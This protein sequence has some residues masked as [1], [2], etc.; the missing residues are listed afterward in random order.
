MNTTSAMTG[1]RREAEQHYALGRAH[2]ARDDL[3]AAEQAYRQALALEPEY[4]DAWVSLGI[5]L[6]AAGQLAEAEKCQREALQLDSRS[7]LAL[8]NL[9][10]VLSSQSRFSE[11]AG[12]FRQALA[13][14][15]RSSKA[16]CNLGIALAQLNDPE[17]GGHFREALRLDPENFEAARHIGKLSLDSGKFEQAIDTLAHACKLQPDS[18]ETRF[19]LATAHFRFGALETARVQFEQLMSD[20]PAWAE[21]PAGLACVLSE[22]GQ[23]S[24]PRA[25]FE[26]ALELDPDD[27]LVRVYYSLLLLRQGEFARGWDFYESRSAA[28]PR[29]RGIERGFAAPR[30]QGEPLAGKTLLVT[31]EQGFGDELLFAS[32]LPEIA[33]DAAHAIVECNERLEKLFRRSFPNATVFGADGKEVGDDRL[34]ERSVDRLP[35]F[36][37]W[38][39]VGSLPRYRRRR[40]EDFPRHD[41]YLKADPARVAYWKERLDALGSGPKVGL[42]WRGGTV[43]TRS[44]ARSLTLEELAPILTTPA[45]HFVSLQ[46][47]D[48]QAELNSF[49]GT[50]GIEIHHWPEAID[51]YDETAALVSALDKVV[52]VCTA[53]VNLTGA[54]NRPIWVMAPLV[55]DARYGWQGPSSIWYP[56]MRVF[57]Q[58]RLNAWAPVIADVRRSL[59]RE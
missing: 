14:N 57:R 40:A 54:L 25:L 13:V 23:Y 48:C 1:R 7:F 31:R 41:G 12:Y 36:D 17:A 59:R 43:L 29:A 8:L 39:P 15:P 49:R 2:K 30:W 42:S 33:N 51:D 26:K 21:P 45:V 18:A 53:V 50:H 11:A 38:I 28:L 32:I 27:V 58:P 44:S 5:L 46:Y 3:M 4:L 47:G 24:K 22:Q 20:Y 55:P 16:H 6:R 19:L 9:G 34:L 52:S 37:Y 10:S 56:S 35:A